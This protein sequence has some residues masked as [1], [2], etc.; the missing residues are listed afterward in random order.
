MAS[1]RGTGS[2]A[3]ATSQS[4]ASSADISAKVAGS[5]RD[6]PVGRQVGQTAPPAATWNAACGPGAEHDAHSSSA[7]SHPASD[8]ARMK[9]ASRTRDGSWVRS[10]R[11]RS[12]PTTSR[13]SRSDGSPSSVNRSAVSQIADTVVHRP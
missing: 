1:R 13:Y 12:A 7:G 4:P 10:A 3:S 5:G 11:V 8:M 9:N 6:D 2:L